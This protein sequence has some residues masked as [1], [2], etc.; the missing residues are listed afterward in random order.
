V[1]DRGGAIRGNRLDV[2]FH[3]HE[4]ALG[5]GVKY[6]DVKVRRK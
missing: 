2:F 1:L 3:T 4:E 5:W 6:L